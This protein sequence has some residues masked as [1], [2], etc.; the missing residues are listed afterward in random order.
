MI[1]I[2]SALLYFFDSMLWSRVDTP[3]KDR[4]NTYNLKIRNIFKSVLRNSN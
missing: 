3:V 2:L 4:T 1:L